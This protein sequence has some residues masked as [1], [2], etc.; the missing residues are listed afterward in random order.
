MKVWITRSEP[1]ATRLAEALLAQGWTPVVA[2]VTG[3]ETLPV[4]P[5]RQAVV[6]VVLS[7]HA[8]LPASV[9]HPKLGFIGIGEQ[10]AV[11]LRAA[12]CAPVVVPDTHDSEGIIAW[13]AERRKVLDEL[14]VLILTGEGGTERVERY[15]R[16]AGVDCLRLNAYRRVRLEVAVETGDV[17][18]IIIGSGEAVRAVAE[19]WLSNGGSGD[20]VVIVPSNRVAQLASEAGFTHVV[21]SA[22]A[23]PD[24]VVRSLASL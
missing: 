12:G 2:P 22:G 5:P 18:A 21:I 7:E 14:P 1:G 11:A 23:S 15:L 13:L 16:S 20:V 19:H 24:A 3:I 10:T 17:N 4:S 6:C 9:V 8:V